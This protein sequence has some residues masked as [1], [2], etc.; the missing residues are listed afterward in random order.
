[1]THDSNGAAT[2]APAG[3]P[4][5]NDTSDLAEVDRW[6]LD[7]TASIPLITDVASALEALARVQM[8]EHAVQIQKLGEERERAWAGVKL[9]A[10]RRYGELLPPPQQGKRTD[11]GPSPARGRLD[12]AASRAKEKARKVHD[13]VPEEVFEE[14]VK[15]D[16]KPTRAGLHRAAAKAKPQS[17]PEP[18]TTPPRQRT[19]RPFTG[20]PSVCDD[21]AVIK[22]VYDREME[23]WDRPRQIAASQ[24]KTDGW[25]VPDD[26][27]SNGTHSTA[28]CVIRWMLKEGYEPGGDNA[29]AVRK[30][31][32]AARIK[33][34]KRRQKAGD[35]SHLGDV[36]FRMVQVTDMLESL[37]IAEYDF[38]RDEVQ[39]EMRE[40]LDELADLNLWSDMTLDRVRKYLDDQDLISKINHAREAAKH[41]SM[42][43]VERRAWLAGAER[44]EAR[45]ERRVMERQKNGHV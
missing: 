11:K 7:A 39:D 26:E 30:R 16:P 42:D 23:G 40:L 22:W 38:D 34:I 32:A 13:D 2:A 15:D 37:D 12:K 10:E 20:S 19:R 36:L 17:P 33:D 44:L 43:E 18:V 6:L 21:P 3:L 8:I 35:L 4:A 5:V 25:P 1:V 31:R 27:L 41:P 28:L 24:A 9:R 45:L 29:P 14:Y